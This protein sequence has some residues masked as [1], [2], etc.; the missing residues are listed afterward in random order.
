MIDCFRASCL[1]SLTLLLGDTNFNERS[2]LGPTQVQEAIPDILFLNVV[3]TH[4]FRIRFSTSTSGVGQMEEVGGTGA[5]K[6]RSGDRRVTFG[7]STT[8]TSCDEGVLRCVEF[9]YRQ[10]A[11]SVPCVPEAPIKWQIGEYQFRRI[12]EFVVGDRRLYTIGVT[13]EGDEYF[14]YTYSPQ[15]GVISYSEQILGWPPQTRHTLFIERGH[16][17]SCGSDVD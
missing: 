6:S 16:F 13:T 7:P 17:L 4:R 9:Q 8:W 12:S 3:G 11:F 15:D 10:Q 14:H 2:N 1:V 5:A